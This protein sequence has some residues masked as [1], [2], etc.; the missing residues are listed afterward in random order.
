MGPT[1]ETQLIL[2]RPLAILMGSA[3]AVLTFAG[4]RAISD[5]L[6]PAFLALVLTI[7]VHPLGPWLRGKGWPGWAATTVL[8]TMTYLVILGLAVALVVSVARFAALLP[9]YQDQFSTLVNGAVDQ[10]KQ[11]GIGEKQISTM[12]NAFN[13]GAFAGWVGSLLASLAGMVSDLVFIVM[14]LLFMVVDASWF[15]GRLTL[16]PAGKA[17]VVDAFSA[18]ARGT[19]RY[20]VV[21]TVFGAIVAILDA[22]ALWIIGVP[23]PLLWGLLAFITNYIPNV[24][25]VIGLIPPA[26]LGLLEGGWGMA[27]TVIIVYCVINLILQSVIQP[28]FVGDA[29][30]LSVSLTFLSLVFWAWVLGPLGALLAIPLTLFLKALLV[31][32]DPG[33]NWLR[34]LLGDFGTTRRTT[35]PVEPARQ[36]RTPTVVPD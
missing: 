17:R 16:A 33:N 23:V 36:Q 24:G 25:F 18:F 28:K 27:L 9:D 14:L 4:L 6:A 31:D 35:A 19:R 1:S 3:A 2:P 29:V 11:W 13:V 12:S 15:P 10:L 26:V 21:S 22:V 20:L 32:S 8:V 7:M 5:I 34:P 30:G